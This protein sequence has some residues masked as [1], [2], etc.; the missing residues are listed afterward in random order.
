MTAPKWE[1]RQNDKK[2]KRDPEA[3]YNSKKKRAT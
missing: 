2:E 3:D 1:K